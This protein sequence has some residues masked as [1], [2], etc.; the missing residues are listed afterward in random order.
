MVKYLLMLRMDY[1]KAVT[2]PITLLDLNLFL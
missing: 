1:L 2:S